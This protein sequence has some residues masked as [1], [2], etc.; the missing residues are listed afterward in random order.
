MTTRSG[1]GP[2]TQR[3]AIHRYA[4]AS[5]LLLRAVDHGVFVGWLISRQSG[6]LETFRAGSNFALV[7]GTLGI[8][9]GILIV[10]LAADGAGRWLVLMTL[11]DGTGR[12]AV[13]VALHVFPGI[14]ASLVTIVSFFGLLGACA[15]SLGLGAMTVWALLRFRRRS[16]WS[17]DSDAL[18][19][20]LAV[21]ALLS[22]AMGYILFI[23]PPTNVLALHH[24]ATIAGGAMTLAFVVA[25]VGAAAYFPHGAARAAPRTVP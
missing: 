19:D 3:P 10:S 25:A 20:P 12:L 4:L 5:L 14:P 11:L 21:T 6:W 17:R 1:Q 9:I 7:D 2:V 22:F 8:L 18:F 15:T 16:E 13:G 24:L 23:H